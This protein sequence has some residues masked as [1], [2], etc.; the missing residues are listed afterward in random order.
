VGN[1]SFSYVVPE[2]EAVAGS[3]QECFFG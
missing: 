2:P 3:S 1:L